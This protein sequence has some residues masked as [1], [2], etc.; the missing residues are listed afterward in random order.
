VR[1]TTGTLDG[2]AV[3]GPLAVQALGAVVLLALTAVATAAVAVD[4]GLRV[5]ARAASAP[6]R[7][8]AQQ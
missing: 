1:A 3:T 6:V 8:E 4:A 2:A 7:Q 5:R